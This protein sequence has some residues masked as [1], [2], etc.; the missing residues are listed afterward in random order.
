MNAFAQLLKNRQS[1]TPV[2]TWVMSASPLVAEAIG[3][4]GF[5]WAVLDME[6]SPIDLMGLVHLLQAVGNTTLQ[7]VVRVP[8]NDSVM[9]KRVLDAGATSLLFP[10]IQNADE[11][12]RAVAATRYPPDGVRGMA[13]MGRAS[14]FGTTPNFFTTANAGICALLQLETTAA[15]ANLEAIAA[16]PGVDALFVGPADLSGTM[17]LPG[18][19]DHPDV[20]AQMASAAKRAN[21]IGMPIGSVG[22]TPETVA[23]Y[24]A[25]GYDYVA[26]ASDLGL[27][28]RAAQ[29]AAK[30]LRVGA[31][32][33]AGVKTGATGY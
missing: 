17:G 20:L 32:V 14:H 5:D 15:I 22:G 10:F 26:V 30:A 9:V 31:G 23:K 27:L 8:W 25:M 2:G 1:H 12:K 7:P 33:D 19:L 21:A 29:A 18:Q 24:R 3:R 6:H 16:V 4:A 28:M 11:A 13:G